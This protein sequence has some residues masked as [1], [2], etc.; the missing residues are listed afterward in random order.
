MGRRVCRRGFSAQWGDSEVSARAA[1]R[2]ASLARSACHRP[3]KERTARVDARR[4]AR[5][6]FIRSS[7]TWSGAVVAEGDICGGGVELSGLGV[8]SIAIHE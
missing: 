1:L 8:E 4:A 5:D 2:S 6:E 7:R 3:T